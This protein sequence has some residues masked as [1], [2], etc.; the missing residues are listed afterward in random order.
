MIERGHR[1]GTPLSSTSTRFNF[2]IRSKL[3]YHQLPGLFLDMEKKMEY[4]NGARD[5][6]KVLNA[7]DHS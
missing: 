4:K 3:I 7:D 1:E 6:G 2:R 5:H